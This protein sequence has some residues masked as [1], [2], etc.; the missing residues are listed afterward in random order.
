MREAEDD[1]NENDRDDEEE[2]GTGATAAP[3]VADIVCKLCSNLLSDS[4]LS[5]NRLLAA[6][7][8]LKRA[9]Q[10]QLMRERG[11]RRTVVSQCDVPPIDPRSTQRWHACALVCLL[12]LVL[13]DMTPSPSAEGNAPRLRCAALRWVGNGR[14]DAAAAKKGRG[15]AMC[16]AHDNDD[17]RKSAS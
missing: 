6:S 11:A 15:S 14:G 7:S 8:A 5:A 4:V 17:A 9:L 13:D 12:Y 3:L 16:L 2:E 10:L 1:E